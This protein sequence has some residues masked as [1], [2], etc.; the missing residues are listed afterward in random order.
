M[1]RNL[2]VAY[3]SGSDDLG[4]GQM[5]CLFSFISTTLDNKLGECLSDKNVKI[6]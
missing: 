3:S 1:I 2:K 5:K 6:R 4:L